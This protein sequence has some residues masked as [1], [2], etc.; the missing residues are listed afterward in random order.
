M[1]TVPFT[2]DRIQ[3]IIKTYPTPFHIYDE[4]G[5]RQNARKLHE[6]FSWNEGFKEYFAVKALPNPF[7]LNLLKEEGCGTDCASATELIMSEKCGITGE[8]IMFSSNDTPGEEFKL[9]R[10]LG[11]IINLDD[12]THIDMLEKNGGIPETV[13]CRYNPGR[14]LATATNQIMGNLADTK[15]GMTRPQ[16][17]ESFKILRAKGAKRFGIHALLVSCCMDNGYYR[18]LAKELFTLAADIK[19]ETG[20]ETNFINLSGGI[21]IPYLPDEKAIDILAVGESVRQA[22]EEII[23]PAGLKVK[24]FTELG[25]Y[26]T[27]P[28]GF[29]V[30]TVLHKKFTY[31]EYVGVD[32]TAANLMRPAIYGSYH[33]I[34]IMGKENAPQDHI[35]DVTGSLCENNDKFAVDR[36]LPDVEAGDIAVIHDTGAH[37]F[38]MGYNYN[39]KLRS[40][41]LLLKGDGSVKLIRRAETPADYFRTFD[42]SDIFKGVD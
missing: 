34:T 20:I 29:L 41:E 32:A 12:I 24:I 35:C 7:I 14:V 38:S 19:R 8:N 28:Y 3:Q 25:R 11:A 6:A 30:T 27:G 16:L 13:C 22:Y 18:R 9:A 40:A 36:A 4:E 31:K 1:K 37:G 21:G 15:F 26:M 10:Q 2:K 33:H 42:F 17:I 23:V 5:I 39:G